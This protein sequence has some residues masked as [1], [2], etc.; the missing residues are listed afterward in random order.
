[1]GLHVADPTALVRPIALP[2][3]LPATRARHSLAWTCRQHLAQ[4]ISRLVPSSPMYELAGSG[5][6]FSPLEMKHISGISGRVFW[7][8][9]E[10]GVAEGPSPRE[11][12]GV[13]CSVC[14]DCGRRTAF[15]G[16]PGMG[17][18]GTGHP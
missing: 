11:A 12:W 17:W 9:L 7:P 2:R 8:L 15:K 14:R 6:V 13:S 18:G 10:G 5:S 16:E 4:A 1:M 3:A